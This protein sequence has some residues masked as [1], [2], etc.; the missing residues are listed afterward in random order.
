MSEEN[1]DTIARLKSELS[2]SISTGIA[3][4]ILLWEAR[5]QFAASQCEVWHLKLVESRRHLA[6][7]QSEHSMLVMQKQP[8][9]A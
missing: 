9:E 4:E 1:I 5:S 2:N 8:N 6:N 7:K 3:T